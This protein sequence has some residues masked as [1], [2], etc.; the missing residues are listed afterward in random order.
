MAAMATV[1]ERFTEALKGRL[2][3]QYEAV[4]GQGCTCVSPAEARR[5]N[6]D[7]STVAEASAE[8]L[9]IRYVECLHD[10]SVSREFIAAVPIAFARQHALVGLEADGDGVEV[11]LAD[12]DAW[13]H[14]VTI[15]KLLG[16]RVRPIFAPRSEILRAI[17]TAYQKQTG[18]AERIIEELDQTQVLGDLAR[19]A[20]GDEDLL[21]SSGRAPVIRL[22]NLILLE[23]VK[24]RASDV[25]IQPYEDRLVVRLR[26]DGVLHDVFEPPHNLQDEIISRIKVMGGMNIAER[27]LA[28]DGRASVEVGDRRID[29]RIATL[30]TS[31]GERAVLR[32]LDKSIRLYELGGLG[33]PEEVLRQF[34]NMIR[35]DHGIILVT[36]P[37]GSGKTTTL[38]SALKEL[39]SEEMNILTL[40]DPIEYRLE[41][42]SQTQ[43]SEKKGMTFARG[44]RHVLR[45]DPDIIM[46][47][48]IRDSETA[49]MAIQSALTGHLVF[50]TLHTNDAA[51]AVTRMLDLGVEPY[52]VA[53][54]L[55]AVQAQR[56]V[57][58]ICPACR[59]TR[60]ATT[61]ELVRW[62]VTPD[63]WHGRTLYAG[64]RCP[65]C[66]E[67]GYRDRV[68]IF[69]FLTVT[70]P[71]RELILARA[72]ASTLK[73]AAMAEGMTTLRADGLAKTAA[74]ITTLEEVSRVTGRDEF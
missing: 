5:L 4:F 73:G 59:T 65:E 58:R 1:N 74:G 66:L 14:L 10:R 33:M 11:A 20:A 48:E 39:N 63:E 61:E 56:L 9:G 45:Q 46:V 60:Q 2:N 13:P 72:K 52:L 40:E 57:R 27:R 25:H 53:S 8:A 19:A 34:R 23:A 7:E 17:N 69:E 6:V 21:D 38:Y 26:I 50:S 12:L 49:R 16:R 54:S 37:T 36:G 29:L 35:M 68:G 51:G 64:R 28:Q 70:E 67:T 15:G 3:G 47:G 30:P 31:F 62:G 43:V 44:L 41:N 24:R 42:I 71:V 22:V 18:Q 55:L 32:L